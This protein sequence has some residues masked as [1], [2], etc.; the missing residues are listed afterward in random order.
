MEDYGTL[1]FRGP[2]VE[3]ERQGPCHG[4]GRHRRLQKRGL[5]T[6]TTRVDYTSSVSFP[7]HD[8]TLR[9]LFLS[10]VPLLSQFLCK[11]GPGPRKGHW[12]VSPLSKTVTS[13]DVRLLVVTVEVRSVYLNR[14]LYVS[15]P[16]LV[17]LKFGVRPDPLHRVWT[18][19]S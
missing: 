10:S 4:P 16:S 18:L 6:K 2:R 8:R 1:F 9:L 11:G 17:G 3:T 13:Q 14:S 15:F 12:S 19:G 7:H 5:G